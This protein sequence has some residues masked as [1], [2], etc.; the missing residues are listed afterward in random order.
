M[1]RI[2][3][4]GACLY[5]LLAVPSVY[6]QQDLVCEAQSVGSLS[7]PSDLP[8]F[9]D[10]DSETVQFEAG[11]IEAQLIPEPRASMSGGVLVRRGDRLAGANNADYD[12]KTR[13]LHLRGDVNYRDPDSE[14]FSQ[15]ADFAY[16][17]GQI[18][19]E[20]AEFLLSMNR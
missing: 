5:L 10:P 16:D 8:D 9:G 4:I 20:N 1:S 6:A 19:F 3:A 17:T 11:S 2:P 15:S 13:S 18:R 12:P 7:D 14:I